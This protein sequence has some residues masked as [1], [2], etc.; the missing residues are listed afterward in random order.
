MDVQVVP[1]YCIEVNLA[2][3]TIIAVNL[4]DVDNFKFDPFIKTDHFKIAI[5]EYKNNIIVTISHVV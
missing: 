1:C 2:V 3:L 5:R 4:I